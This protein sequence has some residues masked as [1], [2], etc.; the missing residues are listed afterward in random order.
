MPFIELEIL[1]FGSDCFTEIGA[2]EPSNVLWSAQND[3]VVEAHRFFPIF[4]LGCS[5]GRL[6]TRMVSS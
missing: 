3:Q 2:G 5:N 1:M 6:S 4:N